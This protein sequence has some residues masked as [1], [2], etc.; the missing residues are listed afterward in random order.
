M[1]DRTDKI[2]MLSLAIM[3]L[4]ISALIWYLILAMI[5]G[6]QVPE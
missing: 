4:S 2:A 5:F 1:N 6:W 3:S